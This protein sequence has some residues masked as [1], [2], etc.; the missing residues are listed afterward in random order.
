MNLIKF[1][2]V[3]LLL[4]ACGSGPEPDPIDTPEDVPMTDP[5]V[6]PLTN[7]PMIS[8]TKKAV[9]VVAPVEPRQGPWT[10]NSSLGQMQAFAPDA[11]SRQS[12]I[13]TGE[14]GRPQVR[15]VS[16]ALQYDRFSPHNTMANFN[17]IANVLC[18]VGG[19]THEFEVD[20]DNGASFSVP[21]NSVQIT[22]VYSS[23]F[24]G[25]PTVPEGL[26]LS[27]MVGEGRSWST[28]PTR[29]YAAQLTLN[30]AY[31]NF[32]DPFGGPSHNYLVIPPF[33]KLLKVLPGVVIAPPNY[34]AVFNVNN[35]VEFYT[36]P[37]AVADCGIWPGSQLA[38]QEGIPIPNGARI[39]R[40][41]NGSGNSINALFQFVLA[42]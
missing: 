35:R 27:A 8:P 33:A 39:I 20:W 16:L 32:Y 34:G 38:F 36:A 22:A 7:Q 41:W 14:W 2:L 37:A 6:W 23:V 21:C 24:G 3:S 13:K 11:K 28:P 25:P 17:I 40:F 30:L 15:T 29:T 9:N 26:F 4:M 5:R 18:G 31:S 1:V 12:I 10:G 42:L 19:T